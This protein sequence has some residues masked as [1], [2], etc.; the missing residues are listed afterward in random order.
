MLTFLIALMSVT[1]SDKLFDP[2]KQIP[3]RDATFSIEDYDGVTV[4]RASWAAEKY[5]SYTELLPAT[6]GMPRDYTWIDTDRWY[7][8]LHKR[9]FFQKQK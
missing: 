9:G 8:G 2:L 5:I 4:Y 3:D 6:L 7:K 1:K